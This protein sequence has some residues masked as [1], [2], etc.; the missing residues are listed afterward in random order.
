MKELVSKRRPDAARPPC[1]VRDAPSAL[2]TMR[3]VMDSIEKPPHP[4]EAATRLSR[5]THC[6]DPAILQFLHTL[7]GRDPSLR[8]FERSEQWQYLGYRLL[9]PAPERRAAAD[10][11]GVHPSRR[12]P[13]L[14]PA[15]TLAYRTNDPAPPTQTPPR[16]AIRSLPRPRLRGEG[17][18]RGLASCARFRAHL[19]RAIPPAERRTLPARGAGAG[20]GGGWLTY[21]TP[22]TR[23]W[24]SAK[25]P[26]RMPE[27]S[28]TRTTQLHDR[29]TTR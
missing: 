5:R 19:A 8:G 4:E 14:C 6:A 27:I 22:P 11:R 16:P 20:D 28:T 9:C 17:R 7:E 23:P 15:E 12:W 2:L 21:K 18:V 26:K 1:V 10:R 25:W 29:S 13:R 24:R 3:Y